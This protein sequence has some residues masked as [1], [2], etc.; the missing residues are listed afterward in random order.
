MAIL[1][2]TDQGKDGI[3]LDACRLRK[4]EG[5]PS[6]GIRYIPLYNSRSDRS[7]SKLVAGGVLQ[8][9]S[10]ADL[11]VDA[12]TFE[13]LLKRSL[14]RNFK[15]LNPHTAAREGSSSLL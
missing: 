6:Q 1:G 3:F 15:Q 9:V 7:Y 4:R 14:A 12:Y 13:Q 5:E 8:P 10:L 11:C 2:V